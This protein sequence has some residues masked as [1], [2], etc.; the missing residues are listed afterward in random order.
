MKGRRR[1]GT[2]HRKWCCLSRSAQVGGDVYFRY[3]FRNKII[4]SEIPNVSALKL[5]SLAIRQFQL[6]HRQFY[7]I[8]LDIS[9]RFDGEIEG[10]VQDP[11][12][13]VMNV[14]LN[15]VYKETTG[16]NGSCNFRRVVDNG[17]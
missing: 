9:Q 3:N 10:S 17:F 7:Q 16:N 2:R 5:I 11:R 4:K 8:I 1:G 12:Q 15:G 13:S 14:I 6:K